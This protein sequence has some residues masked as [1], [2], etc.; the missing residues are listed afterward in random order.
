MLGENGKY[1]MLGSLGVDTDTEEHRKARARAEAIKEFDRQARE[2]NKIQAEKA[3]AKKAKQPLVYRER[4]QQKFDINRSSDK[5]LDPNTPEQARRH[6]QVRQDGA[7]AK[8]S[9]AEGGEGSTV[10]ARARQGTGV[11]VQGERLRGLHESP[12]GAGRV[13]NGGA[14]EAGD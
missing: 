2:Q 11:L 12:G 8:T 5:P 7:K 13:S 14:G 10:G 1:L 4:L 6:A 3:R 9:G